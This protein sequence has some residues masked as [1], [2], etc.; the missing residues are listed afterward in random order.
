MHVRVD[1]SFDV[2][3]SLSSSGIDVAI[4]VVVSLCSRF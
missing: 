1:P 2:S 3:L 4:V